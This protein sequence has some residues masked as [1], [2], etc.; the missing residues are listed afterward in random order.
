[1]MTGVNVITL[2]AW[3]NRY[4]LIVPERK[5]SG[6]RLYTQEHIDLIT[7]VV[8]LL[9]RGMRIGQVKAYL[10]SREGE[11]SEQEGHQDIW[12]RFLDGMLA[13][14][15]RFDEEALNV[16]YTEALTYYDIGTVTRKLLRPLLIELGHR[17]ESGLGTIAE[18]HFFA[19]YMRNKLGA[20]F[21]H[22][23]RHS[24]GKKILMA[25]LPGER[26]ETGLLFLALALNECG[27]HPVVLGA[28]MPLEGMAEA[29]EKIGCDA[30][31]LSGVVNPDSEVLEKQLAG[32]V[33]SIDTPVF[34]G[35]QVSVNFTD[36][37]MRAGAVALGADVEIGKKQLE[38]ML[39][40]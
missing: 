13:A 38:T 6:H 30:V 12:H 34:V 9:D 33:S 26:H 15:I 20:R 29:A 25:C 31:V 3:E 8:G 39:S 28:D 17:W 1:M 35:G 27:F 5:E 11:S 2:R 32:L 16:V 23:T 37:I 40:G 18:E 14:V 22:R 19:F 4:G 24:A 36:Q 21:H 7:K 10:E